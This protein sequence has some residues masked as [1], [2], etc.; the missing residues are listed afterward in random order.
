MLNSAFFV[1]LDH[2]LLTTTCMTPASL[3]RF[4]IDDHRLYQQNLLK[5]EKKATFR[6]EKEFGRKRRSVQH[7]NHDHDHD[8]QQDD[9][10]SIDNHEYLSA[11]KITPPMF[12]D[13]C[14]ALLVQLDQ[15][16]C[17]EVVKVELGKKDKAFLMGK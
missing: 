11:V 2:G 8:H 7:D 14:P 15:R 13:L 16:A 6:K 4:V 17:L 1:A 10:Y 12:I 3:L 5:R 9:T